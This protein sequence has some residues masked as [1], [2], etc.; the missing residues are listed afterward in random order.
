MP[1]AT[2]IVP[3]ACPGPRGIGRNPQFAPTTLLAEGNESSAAIAKDGGLVVVH[4]QA[5]ALGITR[6]DA[7]GRLVPTRP[8]A[9]A[10]A[11]TWAP[12][13]K[14]VWG[15]SPSLARDV[16]GTLYAA[17][18]DDG[19]VLATSRDGGTWSAPRTI[20]P[21]TRCRPQVVVGGG[22]VHV[23]FESDGLR[24][25]TSRDRGT[26]FGAPATIA[27]GA[28]RA[29]VAA[30]GRVHVAAI[31]GSPLG[32]YGSANQ[33]VQYASARPVTVSLRDERVPYY[34]S[35]PSVAFD[36]RRKWL[37][38]AYVRGG[39]DG[40]WDLVIAASRNGGATWT[41]TRIGDEPACALHAVPNLAVD[42]ATGTLHLAWY[43]T[44][45]ETARFAHATCATGLARGCLERGR[46]NDVAF[47]RLETVRHASSWIGDSETLLVDERRRVL[48]AIWAQPVAD[49]TTRVFHAKAKLPLR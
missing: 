46:I 4:A 16:D 5:G 26:T 10:R 47:A 11:A 27:S 41:R 28:G 29:L 8:F 17:W 34:F 38:V 45:G 23:V 33:H 42:A 22:A 40:I 25:R 39:R 37:Y 49:G 21:C 32:A 36:P 6:I 18:S 43:D 7:L 44:R 9:S 15:T 12:I 24:L 3:R 2:A 1:N 20:D 31:A 19:I 48:H 14:P 30:D 35:N 13:D